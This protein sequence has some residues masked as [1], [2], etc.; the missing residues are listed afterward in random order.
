MTLSKTA[1][2]PFIIL[3]IFIVLSMGTEAVVCTGVTDSRLYVENARPYNDINSSFTLKV[4]Y[5]TANNTPIQ[6]NE[7]NVTITFANA[8]YGLTNNTNY[9]SITLT[10]SVSEDVVFLINATSQNYTCKTVSFTSRWRT[11]FN[12]KVQLFKT[13]LNSTDPERYNNDFQYVVFVNN[14]EKNKDDMAV[15][16]LNKGVDNL[17]NGLFG[18]FLEN[19]QEL[20][21]ESTDRNIYFWGKYS[22]GTA[23]VKLYEP[24]NYSVYV[25]NNKIEYPSNYF[26]EFERPTTADVE[27]MGNVYDGLKI[28]DQANIS[29]T[30]TTFNNTIFKIHLTK[31]EANEYYALMNIGKIIL[32]AIVYFGGLWLAIWMGGST[33]NN[34]II[35][36]YLV[37]ATPIAL[38]FVFYIR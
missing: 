38:G 4:Y 2:S 21:T 14:N 6:L 8:T 35:G 37:F 26:Y 36:Y 32:V 3:A 34:A 13:P 31:F 12:V 15:Y 18:T 29:L 11:P 30:P 19:G 1:V 5:L 25:M 23:T 10:S 22:T 20:N 27:Y 33:N 24:G 9:W 28:Y 16:A 7:T 17:F